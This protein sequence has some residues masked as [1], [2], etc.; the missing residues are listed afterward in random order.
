[1]TI[2]TVTWSHAAPLNVKPTDWH[3]ETISTHTTLL[4]LIQSVASQ[5]ILKSRPAQ[6]T[7]LLLP[8]SL[9]IMFLC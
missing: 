2:H 5:H 6:Q 9:F 4:W 3:L 7:S 1:M 8:D